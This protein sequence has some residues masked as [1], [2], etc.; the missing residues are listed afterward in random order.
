MYPGIIS[1]RG[2]A[3][4]YTYSIVYLKAA[5]LQLSVHKLK[6]KYTALKYLIIFFLTEQCKLHVYI[7]RKIFKVRPLQVSANFSHCN[8]FLLK[9]QHFVQGKINY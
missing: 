5:D 2:S 3:R 9:V 6:S 4:K 8:Y 1:G 7:I